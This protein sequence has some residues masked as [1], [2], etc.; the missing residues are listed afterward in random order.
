MKTQR[1]VNRLF[2][3]IAK[4]K[5]LLSEKQIDKAVARQKEIAEETGTKP[6]LGQL[7]VEMGYLKPH[8]LEDILSAQAKAN[9]Q[10]EQVAWC[11]LGLGDMYMKTEDFE[12]AIHEYEIVLR[13]Y[14]DQ[15]DVCVSAMRK[16]GDAYTALGQIELAKQ[17]YQGAVDGFHVD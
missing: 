7:L 12:K 15:E 6:L 4:A 13:K 9:R 17:A 11:Q 2:G 3:T 1:Y 14:R 16:I 8:D 5:N 10:R